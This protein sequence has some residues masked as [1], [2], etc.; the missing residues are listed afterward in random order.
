MKKIILQMIL[1]KIESC[2]HKTLIKFG[3]LKVDRIDVVA[4]KELY[5]EILTDVS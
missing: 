5:N 2:E 1:D 3:K 4:L